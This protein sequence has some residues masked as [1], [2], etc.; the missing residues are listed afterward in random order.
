MAALLPI[1]PA[2]VLF[3]LKRVGA[4]K[5]AVDAKEERG[6]EHALQYRDF[7]GTKPTSSLTRLRK[8]NYHELP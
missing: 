4:T 5:S 8:I 2:Y 6:H 1:T 3:P 7:R